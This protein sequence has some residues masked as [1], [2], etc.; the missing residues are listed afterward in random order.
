MID[1]EKL[2]ITEILQKK[3]RNLYGNMLRH[4]S[5]DF[6]AVLRNPNL[7]ITGK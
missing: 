5:I 2:M 7:H 6:W 4:A 3:P 1:N